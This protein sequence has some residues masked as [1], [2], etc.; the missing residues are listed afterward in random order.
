[1]H[2]KGFDLNHLVALD[3]LLREQSVSRAASK[4]HV[5]QSTMSGVLSRLREQFDDRLLVQVGRRMVPT[6]MGAALARPLRDLI[7]QIQA[8]IDTSLEFDPSTAARHFK[9]IAS[10]YVSGV[11]L[12]APLR[13]NRAFGDLTGN[14]PT[15]CSGPPH[16]LGP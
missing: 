12:P 5:T 15:E 3:S 6:T 1:M 14:C 4:L 9:M 11:L 2:F 7:L 13:A 16:L 8:A 10:D